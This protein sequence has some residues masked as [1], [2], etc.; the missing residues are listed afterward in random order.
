MVS[1]YENVGG[2]LFR[3][4]S[5]RKGR[6]LLS[7]LK[8]RAPG[9]VEH[10]GRVGGMMCAG[11]YRFRAVLFLSDFFLAFLRGVSIAAWA[12]AKRAIGTRNGLQLT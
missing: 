10:R 12:A 7:S 1:S 6:P 9:L 3:T 2:A 11:S 8:N 4:K 5:R